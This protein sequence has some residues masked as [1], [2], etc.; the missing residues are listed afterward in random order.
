MDAVAAAGIGSRSI[1]AVLWGA[2]ATA[3]RIG[4]QVVAQVVL[5]RILGPEQYGLFAAALVAVLFS[6]FFS[7]VGLAYGLIQRKEIDE[8]D[9]RFV[10]AWQTVLGVVVTVALFAAAPLVGRLFDDDRLVSLVR[11]LAPAC[12]INAMGATAASLLRRDLDFKS[13]NLATLASYS[14]GFLL[15]GIPL[16]LA[17]WQ[18]SALV[19]AFLTQAL[20]N[21]AILYWRRPHPLRPLWWY[22]A[23]SESLRFG[24][25]I[26]STNLLNWLMTSADRVIIGRTFAMT[27]VG[28]YSTAYNLINL[29]AMTAIALVQS[30]L[31][32]ASSR[33]QDDRARLQA[34]FRTMFA[35][36]ALFAG[37]VFC[38]VAA[39]AP[40]VI[41]ALYGEKWTAAGPILVPLSLAMPVYLAMAMAIPALWASGNAR[42]E[43][44]LQL[45]IAFAM[46]GVLLLA[47]QLGSLVLMAWTVAALY[48]ARAAVIVSATLRV[49]DLPAASLLPSIGHGVG[50][51]AVV[52][53]AIWIADQLL[54]RLTDL[55]GVWLAGDIAV[56]A[57]ALAVA[58]RLARRRLEPDVL[59]LLS[60]L[61][62]RLPAPAALRVRQ[63]M[64]MVA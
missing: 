30:V 26:L 2:A 42:L 36:M 43:F 46:V 10:F 58:L 5:A 15:V 49:I 55:P 35:T 7:D 23:A 3:L 28:L 8:R 31:Y 59:S 61:A 24:S 56:G 18:A 22:P 14:V 11:W 57:V 38:G 60:K 19:A 53:L 52:A 40:T 37:P 48:V 41:L 21:Q 1:T 51:S 20:V 4:V 63:W 33:V 54:R 13:V 34:G 45:P 47:A 27:G 29:P 50:T 62:D 17:G 64:G 12:L 32:A 9:V 44:R 39:V 25:T 6:T 16:A